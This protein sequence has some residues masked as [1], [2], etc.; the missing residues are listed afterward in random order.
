M[1]F[2]KPYL[3]PALALAC[4]SMP[5]HA[6]REFTPQAGLWMIAA[7]RNGEPGRGFSLDVQ[8]NTVFMQVFN[9]EKSGAATF[10]TAVGKLGEAASMTVPLL[11]FKGGRYFGGPA[12]IGVEDGSAG[13]VTVKF[14]NGLAGTI[15]F[16]GEGE[17]PIAR[18]LIPEKLPFWWTQLSD[19]PPSDKKGRRQM[20][21]IATDS[22]GALHTWFATLSKE[23][24]DLPFKLTFESMQ[25]AYYTS[26][27]QASRALECSMELSTQVL[28]CV[29]AQTTDAAANG[30]SA[31][32]LQIRR[33]RLRFLGYDIVGEIQP[34]ANPSNRLVL[35]GTTIGSYSQRLINQRIEESRKTYSWFDLMPEPCIM[36]CIR[37]GQKH[38]T[39]LPTSGAWVLDA[40]RTGKPGRGVFLDVQ[41]DTVIVQTSDYLANGEPTFHLGTSS[42]Q[43]SLKLRGDTTSA[44]S[45]FRY[46]GGRHFGSP[47][48]SAKEVAN[49]GELKLS[50]TPQT[51]NVYTDF[52]TGDVR[53][54]GE[55][56]QRI[57]RL[58][59]EPVSLDMEGMLGEYL[60]TWRKN[61][62]QE[63]RW[64]R[65]TRVEGAVAKNDDGTVQ[66][67]R[68]SSD[69]RPNGMN[70]VWSLSPDAAS[71]A[72]NEWGRASLSIHPFHRETSGT[73]LR[74]RDR[75]GNWLGLGKVSLPGLAIP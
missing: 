71:T 54:P 35:N 63:E 14:A 19:S 53:L 44:M 68:D 23:A 41:D 30:G 45:M 40:E 70:C 2:A 67:K 66:C 9:Y 58:Q 5:A 13:N 16:P 6:A 47:A 26:V 12:Q 15:R 74:T 36:S 59:F 27:R 69:P 65:L 22:S 46:A 52:A 24:D 43:G 18:F 3:L 17:Q 49:A 33:M 75:H 1:R 37:E 64:F 62:A 7:E 42:L 55:G 34:E 50:F 61:L 48:Q 8:G 20:N 10:H 28:D 11:R 60:D 72:E 29:P 56:S 32:A 4:L 31:D 57:K 21:L 25:T 38:I 51:N 73:T 39:V